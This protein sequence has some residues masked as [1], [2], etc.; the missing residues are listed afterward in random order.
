MSSPRFQTSKWSRYRPMSGQI[1]E[2]SHDDAFG[3]ALLWLEKRK[4]NAKTE[5]RG[6]ARGFSL[7]PG[8]SPS[9]R[10][11]FLTCS[12]RRCL[13]VTDSQIT[14]ETVSLRR[15]RTAEV[16]EKNGKFLFPLS[17][18][19]ALCV[20]PFHRRKELVVGVTE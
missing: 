13:T 16:A 11:L 10:F 15:K 19:R 4:R 14:T 20:W 2:L 7:R 17:V 1:G 9:L 6:A 18:L 3:M 12:W 5:R 8:D